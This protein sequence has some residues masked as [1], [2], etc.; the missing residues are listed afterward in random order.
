LGRELF[1]H[2]SEGGVGCGQAAV[3]RSLQEHFFDLLG[4]DAV[5]T[6][7]RKKRNHG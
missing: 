4:R 3:D 5:I 7:A 2:E 6:P 1:R